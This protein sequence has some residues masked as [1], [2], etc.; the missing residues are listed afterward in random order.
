MRIDLVD[1]LSVSATM[2]IIPTVLIVCGRWCCAPCSDQRRLS[3]SSDLLHVSTI[4]ITY[5]VCVHEVLI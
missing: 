1:M 5:Y 2:S 4:M 3:F